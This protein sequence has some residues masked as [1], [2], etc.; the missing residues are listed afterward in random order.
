M[1]LKINAEVE[2]SSYPKYARASGYILRQ[3]ENWNV[4]SG[5]E[6]VDFEVG[7]V[8]VIL[9]ANLKQFSSTTNDRWSFINH[10]LCV[11]QL[12][13]SEEF[14]QADNKESV[15]LLLNAF[16][17]ALSEVD[18]TELFENYATK[19]IQF[20]GLMLTHLKN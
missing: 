13:D 8:P 18:D 5:H 17:A 1:R 10:Q 14:R 15:R 19:F 9:A 11:G 7:F 2:Q 16:H 12:V 6:N 3:F 4:K 20:V